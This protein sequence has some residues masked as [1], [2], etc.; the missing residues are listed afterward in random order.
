MQTLSLRI[1]PTT[2]SSTTGSSTTDIPELTATNFTTPEPLTELG[3]AGQAALRSQGQQPQQ[4][5][6]NGVHTRI[7]PT[8]TPGLYQ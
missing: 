1:R 2:G 4:F 8:W 5:R 7:I 6:P 3:G